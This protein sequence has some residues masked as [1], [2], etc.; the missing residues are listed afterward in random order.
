MGASQAGRAD[1]AGWAGVLGRVGFAGRAGR[2]ERASGVMSWLDYPPVW[3]L[4]ALAVARAET[5]AL[6]SFHDMAWLRLTGDTLFWAGLAILGVSALSFLRARSTIVPHQVPS[7][8]ITT[9]LYRFS[10]NPIYLADLLI[11]G[12]LALS[13]GALSGLVLVPLLA[14]VL[15]RRFILPEEARLRAAFGREA[16]AYFAR[17]RRWL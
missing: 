8:L 10:R 2:L 16:E 13:W 4:T 5:S 3:L 7:R 11:L 12:G 17:T 9:G 15:T 6:G 14:W 1:R